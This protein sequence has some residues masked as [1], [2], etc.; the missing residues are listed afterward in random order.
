MRKC[1]F[2]GLLTAFLLL[3]A[4]ALAETYVLDNIRATVDVPDSYIVLTSDNLSVYEEWLV[5]RGTTMEDAANDMVARGVLLQ[6]WTSEYDACFELTAV[7]NDETLNMFDVN[8]Q[9]TSV[10][11]NYRLGHYPD[12]IYANEGYDFS[13]ADWKNTDNGRFLVMRYT[14]RD[15]SGELEYRGLMRRTIRNGYEITFDMRIYGRSIINK[16]NTALNKIWDTFKF[17]EILPLPPAASAKIN[18]TKTPPVETNDAN[19][20]L[21]GTAAKDVKLTAVVMGLSY[22]DPMLF[23]VEVGKS[24]KFKLPI[25][26]PKEGV[27]MLT[28]TG[29]YQGEVVVELAYPVTYQRT[30]LM[31]NVTSTVPEFTSADTLTILGESVAGSQIQIFVNNEKYDNKKVTTAGK[32]KVEIETKQEGTYDIVL[33]FSKSGLADRRLNYTVTRQWSDADTIKKL[34]SDAVS[35]GYSTLVKKIEGYDG[36]TMEYKCYVLDITQSGDEWI[37]KMALTKKGDK[38]SGII[39]VTTDQEPTLTLGSRVLMYGTCAGMSLPSETDA[40]SYPCFELL[41]FTSLE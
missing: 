28:L 34:K 17:V 24:G 1:F 18:I 9:T 30:L 7:Q 22:P 29:E 4:P 19:F 12:N 3:C 35:P 16:D 38:Y 41:L 20:T 8:E 2:V 10:R 14:K 26:L 13:S 32:F 21:E 31:I 36:R 37:V 6:C 15:S 27:F 40:D 39:L 25:K 5:S 33:A 11:G 23:E